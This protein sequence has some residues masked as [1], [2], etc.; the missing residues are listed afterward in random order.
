[1]KG[2]VEKSILKTVARIVD[3]EIIYFPICPVFLHQ[4]KRPDSLRRTADSKK[5]AN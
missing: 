3:P 5:E 4:P 1:M 2:K